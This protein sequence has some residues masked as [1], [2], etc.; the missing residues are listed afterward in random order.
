MLR[1]E[2]NTTISFAARGNVHS[3]FDPATVK[4]QATIPRLNEP[5]ITNYNACARIS[6][7]GNPGSV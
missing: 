5:F 6:K 2:S 3:P 4:L 7:R 1:V